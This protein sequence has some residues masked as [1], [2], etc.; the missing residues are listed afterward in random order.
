[1]GTN[2]EEFQENRV[3]IIY[4]CPQKTCDK[5][6]L[7]DEL[8]KKGYQINAVYS[9]CRISNV[10]QR[11]G[12]GKLAARLLTLWQCIKGLAK[13][14]PGDRVICWSQWSGLF[15]NLLPGAEKCWIISYNWLT[16]IPN[17]KT[18]FLYAKALENP[19]LT[20]VINTP[21][22]EEKLRKAYQV[23]KGGNIV[24]IPDVFDDAQ[25]FAAPC[26]KQE[27]RYCFSGGRAN[28]DWSLL[29]KIAAL[30][31][32][33]PFRVV[34][35]RADWDS[36]LEIP[37][38]VQVFF[39]LGPEDYYQLLQ[40]SYLSLYPLKENR[41]SGLINIL[42]SIQMG[43]PVLTTDISFTRI[44]FSQQ[45]QD[46][47]L[48]FGDSSLWKTAIERL[49]NCGKDE[50]EGLGKELQEY[51]KRNFSPQ[52]AVQQLDRIMKEK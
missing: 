42:K 49:W 48:P 28:R 6:W 37:S 40:Q 12:L 23:R 36:N 41:V 43:K 20:A 31:P 30:C 15:F 35:A 39:D 33:I 16:P 1:M 14:K 32:H 38:N 4:D 25:T 8:R 18:R 19:R 52:Q 10:E 3:V 26:W 17:A 7:R 2:K 22:T 9:C 47:L 51:V 29:M 21:E 27:N 24:C 45:H 13:S 46:C 44:Y 11:G 5:L 34:S 50:Y